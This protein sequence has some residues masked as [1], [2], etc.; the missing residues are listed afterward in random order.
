MNIFKRSVWV[1]FFI[2]L[3]INIFIFV[4]SITLG[5]EINFY[6]KEIKKVHQENIE[7]SNKTYEID[8]L[9]YAASMAANL[10]FT[11]TAKPF[12]LEGQKYA[13]NK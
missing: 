9:Q 10:E 8:S 7:L 12:Y 13:L 11:Q 6:E 5:S 3:S 4:H 2:L 1:I